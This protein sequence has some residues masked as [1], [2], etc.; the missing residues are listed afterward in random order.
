MM[1]IRKVFRDGWAITVQPNNE[2]KFYT[3]EYFGAGHR[4]VFPKLHRQGT[5][6]VLSVGPFLLSQSNL[7]PY[8]V[9]D[10]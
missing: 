6:K 5:T 4:W 10:G 9:I 8:K 3:F 7:P 1:L 2:A